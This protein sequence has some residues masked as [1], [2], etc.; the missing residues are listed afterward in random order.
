M[1]NAFATDSTH[2]VLDVNGFF[3]A[4]GSA[5]ELRLH[6]IVP[7]RVADTRVDGA[8]I[9]LQAS[10][11]RDFAVGGVCG[12]PQGASGYSLNV[13][14]VPGGPLGYLTVWPA[15]TMRPLVS[16]L[17]SP[18]GRIL[19]NAALVPAG[20]SGFVSVYVTN[21]T[22]VILDINGYFN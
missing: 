16:T 7:C 18:A 2:L 6:P 10:E 11:T 1:V 4:T 17:N 9:P 22:H 19:A 5:G 13:T 12:V 21:Q 20:S 14:V 8:G 3:G 15:G